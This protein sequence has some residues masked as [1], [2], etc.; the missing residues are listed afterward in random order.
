MMQSCK[1]VA[2]ETNTTPPDAFA[3]NVDAEGFERVGRRAQPVSA[4]GLPT[5]EKEE[6]RQQLSDV[7]QV[8]SLWRIVSVAES[9]GVLL[10]SQSDKPF[11]D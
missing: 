9:A 3:N 1:G 10:T 11:A 8:R 7:L 6:M 5:K 2:S 4:T